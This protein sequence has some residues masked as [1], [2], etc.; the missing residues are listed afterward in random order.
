VTRRRRDPYSWTVVR[1]PDRDLADSVL[2]LASPLL[3]ALG[4]RPSVEDACGAIELVVSFWNASVEA[5]QLWGT[6][7]PKALRELRRRLGN[8]RAPDGDATTFDLLAQRW[9]DGFRLDPRLVASWTYDIDELGAR[10][11]TCEMALPEGVRAEVPP[12]IEKRISIGGVFLDEVR[13]RLNAT[14][15]LGFPV[16]EHRAS[17]GPDGTATVEA[18][19]PTALQLFAEGRLPHVGGDPVDVVI[20]GRCIGP[21]VLSE[22]RCAGDHGR[23]DTAV[24]LFR[25]S[26]GEARR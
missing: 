14:S 5:S 21:M 3:A 1:L 12:P 16:T 22:V 13:I 4:D 9:R 6:P 19:M 11:L 24:L 2:D 17:I 26:T 8:T 15:F 7:S 10:R 20:G 25:P 18:R 23:H